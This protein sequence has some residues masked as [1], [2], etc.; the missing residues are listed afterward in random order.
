MK[1]DY[2]TKLSSATHAE[3]LTSLIEALEEWFD[4]EW[5]RLEPQIDMW[6]SGTTTER[7]AEAAMGVLFAIAENQHYLIQEGYFIEDTGS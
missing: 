2:S 5:S 4:G 3:V 7:M 6:V 1:N